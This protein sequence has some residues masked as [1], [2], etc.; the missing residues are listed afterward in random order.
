MR[1]WVVGSNFGEMRVFIVG[2][3]CLDGWMFDLTGT[4]NQV[5]NS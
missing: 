4:V 2:F 5:I 1:Y 3:G